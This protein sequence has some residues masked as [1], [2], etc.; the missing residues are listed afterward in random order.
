MRPGGGAADVA[1]ALSP[2]AGATQQQEP[3]QQQEAE[4][5]GGASP[6]V[7]GSAGQ[8]LPS[9]AQTPAAAAPSRRGTPGTD[10]RAILGTPGALPSSEQQQLQERSAAL[11][12]TAH[13]FHRDISRWLQVGA[14]RHFI[15]PSGLATSGV[16]MRQ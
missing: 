15:L 5:G 10:L 13:A 9:A 4:A 2:G 16:P 1:A 11:L 7:P 6:A 14:L 12:Q 3:L 8:R